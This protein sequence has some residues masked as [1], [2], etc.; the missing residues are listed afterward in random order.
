MTLVLT[1]KL[2]QRLRVAHMPT[3]Q[4]QHQINKTIDESRTSANNLIASGTGPGG[5]I[6]SESGGAII[7]V[8][9]GDFVGIRN[10]RK[11]LAKFDLWTSAAL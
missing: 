10:N 9:R 5:D 6:M 8:R 4:Q 7:S 11:N 3:A 2:G 1:D